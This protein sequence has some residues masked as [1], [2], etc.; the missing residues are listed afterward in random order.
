MENLI[1]I[2]TDTQTISARELHK[3]LK[4][5]TAFKDWMPRMIEYGFEEGK[6]FCSF[7][8]ESTG[9]RPSTEY[10]ITIEMAKEICMIQRTPEGREVRQALIE[11]EKKWNQ[12]EIVMARALKMAAGQIDDLK[13]ENQE[14][15]AKIEADKPKT[16]FADA[17][18][19]SKTSILIGDLAKLICQNGVQ[20]GQKRLFDWLRDN[21]YLIKSG[22]SRNMPMQRYVEQGLFEVKESTFQ[23]PDGSVRITKTTK[24]TGKG[25]VYFVNKF[26]G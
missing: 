1:K 23:N 14:L 12:P 5:K 19:T 26:I 7:L 10:E 18:S 16:I 9:G 15:T 22:N 4:I 6:D 17:V 24:V 21:G 3:R 25:Q 8:S 2:D 11:L 13:L 20:I